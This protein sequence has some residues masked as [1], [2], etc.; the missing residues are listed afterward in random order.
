VAGRAARGASLCSRPTSASQVT[1]PS[2]ASFEV[3]LGAV[4]GGGPT[5]R[6]ARLVG[7]GRAS[8]IAVA[9][10]D[11]PAALAAEYGY[12]NR[13]VPDA[14]LAA[15][16]D[17]F[18]RR[19]AGFDKIAVAGTKALLDVASLPADDEFGPGL[20]AF[21]KTSGRA[22]TAERV[23]YLRERG[24]QT[25]DGVERDLGRAVAKYATNRQAGEVVGVERRGTP[26]VD[27][28]RRDF[29]PVQ[30]AADEDYIG[31]LGASSPG[32]LQADA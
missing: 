7:R 18:A 29:E 24:Y 21:F 12:V 17:A 1:K 27:L 3:G 13:V 16:I 22:E 2:S 4:P 14:G 6:L 5:A 20:A 15:F 26:C 19:V 11:F 23:N 31:S 28:L 8:E 10:D 25:P 30:V 9:A 32:G